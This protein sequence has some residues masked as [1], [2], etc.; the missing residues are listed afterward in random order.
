M[1]ITV[2]KDDVQVY[3]AGHETNKEVLLELCDEFAGLEAKC[4]LAARTDLPDDIYFTCAKALYELH[5]KDIDHEIV[6]NSV[7]EDIDL[8]SLY[9]QSDFEDIR[10]G[11]AYHADV[12][13]VEVQEKLSK[14]EDDVV[15][16][17]AQCSKNADILVDIIKYADI[18]SAT[19]ALTNHYIPIEKLN[20]FR[21]RIHDFD[22]NDTYYIKNAVD[23]FSRNPA[24]KERAEALNNIHDILVEQIKEM[25]MEER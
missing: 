17:L 13:P 25:E 9:A 18:E 11:V 6:Y 22:I 1:D 23:R 20:V 19:E 5:N 3:I 10:R 12:L 16:T 21:E 7:M 14:D 4:T 8:L 15:Y 24:E 2:L